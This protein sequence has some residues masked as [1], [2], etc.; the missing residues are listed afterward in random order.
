[1][2]ISLSRPK[3]CNHGDRVD[4]QVVLLGFAV[5]AGEGDQV[6]KAGVAVEAGSKHARIRVGDPLPE[7]VD[8]LKDL[9]CEV[10]LP[11]HPHVFLAV[12]DYKA[13]AAR[14]KLQWEGDFVR[15]SLPISVDDGFLDEHGEADVHRTRF[16]GKGRLIGKGV[17]QTL[18]SAVVFGLLHVECFKYYQI[19]VGVHI[20]HAVHP[21]EGHAI[22]GFVTAL[23]E[24][25]GGRGYVMDVAVLEGDSV[26]LEKLARTL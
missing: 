20:E 11:H 16:A 12:V 4:P 24:V 18:H 5:Y 6:V 15:Q 23:G 9:V 10:S 13:Y 19:T 1:M 25:E 8:L 26:G 3:G 22:P 17:S 2:N 14:K 21:G 7:A